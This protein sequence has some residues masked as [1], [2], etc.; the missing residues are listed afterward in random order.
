MSRLPALHFDDLDP[1]GQD[2]WNHIV[3]SRGKIVLTAEETLAGPFNA[4]VTAPEIGSRL[5]DLGS[6]LRFNASVE[7]RLL[8]LAIVT[9]GAR[10][11]AE[12]EW[13]AHARWA[14]EHGISQDVLDALAAGKDPEFTLDDERTVHAIASQLV[15][16]GQ[17]D[18][19]TYD[20]GMALLGGA[21]MVDLVTLC[22]Y[23]TTVSFTLN[24]FGVELPP[25]VS[26][27][28]GKPD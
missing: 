23:Y 3:D 16:S 13:W 15:R 7:R 25:G 28:W 8:E 19:E 24:T 22:G 11:H 21:G 27:V 2:L 10:W 20:A 4:W 5:T 17:V 18:R 6:R 26:P 1:A 14:R 12:F 9:V